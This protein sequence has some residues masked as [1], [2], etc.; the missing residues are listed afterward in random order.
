VTTATARSGVQIDEVRRAV[1]QV[2]DP[3]MPVV[4]IGM[5]GMVHSVEVSAEGAV[6]VEL[7]PTFAGCP[8]TDVIREDVVTAAAAVHGVNTV[9]VRFRFDPPW[10]PARINAEGHQALRSFGIAPPLPGGPGRGLG[11]GLPVVG[12]TVRRTCPY[13]GSS[14]TDLDSSFGPT[15]CRSI[16]FCNACRQPFEAFKS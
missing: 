3:E 10:T 13:C 14:D 6:S 8:A 2:L 1:D 12:I 15:P 11:Q 16:H 4:T 9:S 5:L 7:L